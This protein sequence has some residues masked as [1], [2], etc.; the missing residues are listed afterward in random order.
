MALV[1]KQD[2]GSDTIFTITTSFSKLT[3][4]SLFTFLNHLNP[5][6][7]NDF[8]LSL[9]NGS[10]WE[11]WQDLTDVNI[12]AISIDISVSLVAQVRYSPNAS[13]LIINDAEDLMLKN[14]SGDAILIS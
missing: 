9:D 11:S 4:N 7:A 13:Y 3:V 8:R 10:T 1:T 2:I 5:V 12:R 6:L 14:D